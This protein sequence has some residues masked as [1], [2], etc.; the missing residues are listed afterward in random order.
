MQSSKNVRQ[1]HSSHTHGQHGGRIGAPDWLDEP[2][3]GGTAGAEGW[4]GLTA[5]IVAAR[6]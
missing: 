6:P 2:M 4:K 5:R 1:S 3:P